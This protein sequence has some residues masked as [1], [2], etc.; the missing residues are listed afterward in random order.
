MVSCPAFFQPGIVVVVVRSAV[1]ASAQSGCALIAKRLTYAAFSSNY[2][3][4]LSGRLRQSYDGRAARAKTLGQR[5]QNFLLRLFHLFRAVFG[6]I[7]K[8]VQ[9]EQ[10]MHNAQLKLVR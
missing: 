7:V 10:S 2:G 6:S 8:A 1:A 5:A 4:G 3:S 9:M